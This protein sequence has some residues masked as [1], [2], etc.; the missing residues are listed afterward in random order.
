MQLK[1]NP[2]GL[3]YLFGA[4]F[5]LN[6]CVKDLTHIKTIYDNNFEN[7]NLKGITTAGWLTDINYGV[8]PFNKITTFQNNKVLGTFNN[9][10][11]SM[12]FDNLTSH[13]IV[14]VE[15]DLYLHDNWQ[16]NLFVMTMDGEYRLISGFSN[17]ST[18]EQAYPN[19][20]NQVPTSPAGNQAQE[21]YL[22]GFFSKQNN[23]RGSSHYKIVHSLPHTKSTFELVLSDA[24]GE[25]NDTCSRSWSIDN[26]K[27]VT[28]EN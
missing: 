18:V 2:V 28:L 25:R 27:I 1:K 21:I 20:F 17:D 9:S 3:L 23:I 19:W 10:S 5:L 22:P 16:N 13:T 26:I 12:S 15:F 11:A 24:G 7:G 14:R 4:F 6:G 8:F